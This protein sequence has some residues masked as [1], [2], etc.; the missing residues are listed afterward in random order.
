VSDANATVD[1][2]RTL[3]IWARQIVTEW[4]IST[5]ATYSAFLQISCRMIHLTL[6]FKQDYKKA[7]HLDDILN[8]TTGVEEVLDDNGDIEVD[9]VPVDVNLVS[10]MESLDFALLERYALYKLDPV[11][12][13]HAD[14][15]QAVKKNWFALTNM[16]LE[17]ALVAAFEPCLALPHM[18]EFHAVKDDDLAGGLITNEQA[19]NL[20]ELSSLQLIVH[21]FGMVGGKKLAETATDSAMW[22]KPDIHAGL[23][24]HQTKIHPF[25][26]DLRRMNF[27][28]AESCLE[29]IKASHLTNF[30]LLAAG[31]KSLPNE[32]RD[33]YNKVA[34]R[35]R[36]DSVRNLSNN[37]FAKAAKYSLE[38]QSVFESKKIN[39]VVKKMFDPSFKKKYQGEN[40]LRA[41]HGRN[42][43]RGK[44]VRS[45]RRARG[46]ARRERGRGP[47][48]ER[49]RGREK[50]AGRAKSP[51]RREVMCFN[52][53]STEHHANDLKCPKM[54]PKSRAV[55]QKR[56]DSSEVNKGEH[57]RR[58]TMRLLH[59]L[60]NEKKAH[61]RKLGA[62]T[63]DADLEEGSSF[64][65]SDIGG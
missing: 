57:K 1:V 40:D 36:S 5:G 34:D 54:A 29:H 35:I 8:W 41:L 11:S 33:V 20:F 23:A 14:R 21:A 22:E 10:A 46:G 15:R 64:D 24:A 42:D 37:T 3:E 62:N 52:C 65:E 43:T 48:N 44:N 32:V 47:S 4:G 12:N 19:D 26:D 18:K 31:T 58:D 38:L 13:A 51:D 60:R 7:P 53:D 27:T 2:D 25:F 50:S 17:T 30:I 28:N 59:Q 45:G 63:N 9:H 39:P 55:L 6:L 61:F 56:A 49:E 16:A